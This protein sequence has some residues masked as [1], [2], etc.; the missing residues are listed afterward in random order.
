MILFYIITT[1][2][3]CG[4]FAVLLLGHVDKLIE[5]QGNSP[6]VQFFLLGPIGLLLIILG[7]LE[8][9]SFSNFLLK[10]LYDVTNKEKK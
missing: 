2:I 9:S 8:Y 5:F 6:I 1:W 3:V 10:K 4:V 7:Y